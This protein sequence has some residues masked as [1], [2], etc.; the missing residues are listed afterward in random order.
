LNTL[1]SFLSY[2]VD[3][4]LPTPTNSVGMGNKTLIDE[5]IAQNKKVQFLL[6]TV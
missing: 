6:P 2:A 1:G 5:V 3:K 4:Q